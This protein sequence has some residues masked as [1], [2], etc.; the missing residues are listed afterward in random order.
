MKSKKKDG[1]VAKKASVS[2]A[3]K[4]NAK[5]TKAKKGKE[6]EFKVENLISNLTPAAVFMVLIKTKT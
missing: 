1:T 6:E 3:T 4:P 2:E 5:K